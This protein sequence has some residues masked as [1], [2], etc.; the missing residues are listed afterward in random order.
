MN[1]KEQ[2]RKQ[3]DVFQHVVTAF[4]LRHGSTEF[5]ANELAKAKARTRRVHVKSN[6]KGG[7]VL[8]RLGDEPPPQESDET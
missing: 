7:V 1:S 6:G 4:V 2:L 8:E 3:R 5:T